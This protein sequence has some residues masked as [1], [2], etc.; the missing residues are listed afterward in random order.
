MFVESDQELNE[1]GPTSM[2]VASVAT[3]TGSVAAF[4]LA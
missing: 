3:S 2:D 1:N 4:E